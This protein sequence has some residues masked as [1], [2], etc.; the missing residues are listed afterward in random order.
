MKSILSFLTSF[1][2]NKGANMFGS[3][4][5]NK[6]VLFVNAVF[7]V[8][9]INQEDYG[10]IAYAFSLLSFFLPFVGA[11]SAQSL[12]RF[13]PQV[14]GENAKNA[15]SIYSFSLGL[16][17]SLAIARFI[18]TFKSPMT[19]NLPEAKEI[20]GLFSLRFLGWFLL[21]QRKNHYRAL[22]K[23]QHYAH[24]DNAYSVVFLLMSFGLTYFFDAQGY[25][26]SL[27]LSPFLAYLYLVLS[28][29]GDKKFSLSWPK[30]IGNIISKK[31]FWTYG[32]LTSFTSC[33]TQLILVIDVFC[34]GYF[35]SDSKEIA[36][37]K[38][39]SMI[40]INLLFLPQIFTKTDFTKLSKNHS[41]KAFLKQY[42]YSFFRFFMIIGLLMVLVVFIFG[43]FM[44]P[45]IFGKEYQDAQTFKI[46]TL[47]T[48]AS[49]IF[50]TP[51][52]NLL[53]AMGEAKNN[54]LIAAITVI[55]AVLLNC[56]LIPR[57][58]IE[59][60]A[61]ATFFS[62]LIS[63]GLSHFYFLHCLKKM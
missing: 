15:L 19:Y 58:G 10:N 57:W 9:W 32:I 47:A 24:I 37:Y 23:N 44:F 42:Y 62:F 49:M 48:F 43:D 46:L 14:Q 38:V 3:S 28:S 5:I 22:G 41:N 21:E 55:V 51:L 59:G 1:L 11:G 13:S 52:G 53:S 33:L 27:I 26:W 8:R 50:R 16:L 12:A 18:F 35:L 7:V 45:L 29:M 34:L 4:V 20:L 2:Q 30:E 39:S 6:I 36:L 56:L 54:A 17:G 40:P 31:E 25:I 61:L 63:G 60:A